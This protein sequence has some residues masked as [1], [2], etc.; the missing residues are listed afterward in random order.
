MTTPNLRRLRAASLLLI[1]AFLLLPPAAASD[2]EQA[3]AARLT[4]EATEF[5]D[6][7]LGPGRARVLITVEAEREEVQTQTEVT[8]PI[9][10][11]GAD[12]QLMPGQAAVREMAAKRVDYFQKDLEKSSRT[13]GLSV[14]RLRVAVVL[15]KSISQAQVDEVKDILYKL[16]RMEDSRGDDLSILRASLL[17][18]WKAALLAPDGMRTAALAAGAA[19]G[20]LLLCLLAFVTV[21]RLSAALAATAVARRPADEGQPPLAPRRGEAAELDAVLLPDDV[22]LLARGLAGARG[23]RAPLALLGHRFDFLAKRNPDDL[24]PLL[25]K[26]P[27]EDLA[28]FFGYLAEI[29][30]DLAA[31]LFSSLPAAL[32][33]ETSRALAGLEMADPEKLA[34]LENR[35][36]TAVEFGVQGP[37]RLGQILSRMTPDEREEVLGDLTD[38]DPAATRKVERFLF[39]FERLAA[40]RPEELQRVITAVPYSQWALALRGASNDLVEV[41]FAQLPGGARTII[42]E[43]METPAAK[44]KVIEARSAVLG[45]LYEL[46]ASGQVEL[47]PSSEV[48]PLE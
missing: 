38:R 44:E 25:A 26:E 47:R 4:H 43:G 27:P 6:S 8:T 35:I 5:L 28:L 2:E 11:S 19:V 32:R 20:A 1:S 46:A 33:A 3:L 23:G 45:R 17:P 13:S 37:E 39:P 42:R 21:W 40:L 31:R 7:L 22:P 16:L 30:A 41:I 12:E 15:D 14:K 10:K 36:R 18:T 29:K 24:A 48:T 34:M 9:T